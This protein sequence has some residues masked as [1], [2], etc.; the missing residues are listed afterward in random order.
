M[1]AEKEN[2]IEYLK[3]DQASDLQSQKTTHRIP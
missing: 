3:S 2:T 1:M